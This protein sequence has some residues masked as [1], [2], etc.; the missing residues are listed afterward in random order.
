MGEPMTNVA[1]AVSVDDDPLGVSAAGVEIG[2][3]IGVG[4]Y[5]LTIGGVGWGLV[6]ATATGFGMPGAA[7]FGPRKDFKIWIMW[8][9]RVAL[10]IM[11]RT[12]LSQV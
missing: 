12:R 4:D 3:R 7:I 5:A 10:M 2:P 9:M 8:N 6:K 11:K 1:G